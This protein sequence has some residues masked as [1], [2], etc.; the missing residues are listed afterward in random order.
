MTSPWDDNE[1]HAVAREA[2]TLALAGDS[3]EAIRRLLDPETSD[4]AAV[5]L[6]ALTVASLRHLSKEAGLDPAAA[7]AMMAARLSLPGEP[8]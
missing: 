3:V 8:S 6:L 5:A 2:V 1:G 4:D 7:W